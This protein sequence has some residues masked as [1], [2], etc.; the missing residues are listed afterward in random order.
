MT[1]ESFS[2]KKQELTDILDKKISM[3]NGL[4]SSEQE[5]ASLA[6]L[7]SQESLATFPIESILDLPNGKRKNILGGLNRRQKLLKSCN[8]TLDE[9]DL[10]DGQIRLL[11]MD[12]VIEK[13]KLAL[14][15][16]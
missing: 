13:I 3:I 10:M 9:L 12:L 7:D 11:V 6:T 8:S 1:L 15:S 2:Q 4:I 14:E 5:L 16:K